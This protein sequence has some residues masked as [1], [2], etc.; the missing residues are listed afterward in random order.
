MTKKNSQAPVDQHDRVKIVKDLDK[1]ILV[2]A[3]AGSGKTESLV[4]RMLALLEENR[5]TVSTLAAV[6]FTNKAAAELRHRFQIRLEKKAQESGFPEKRARLITALQNLE[7]CFIGTIH[8]FCAKLLR[9][10]PVEAGLDPD[11]R[12]MENI[13]EAVFRNRAWFAFLAKSRDSFG[14]E[15]N[16]LAKVG[17]LPEDLGDAFEVL[18][19]FPDI[20]PAAGSEGPPDLNDLRCRLKK[21]LENTAVLVP[22]DVPEKGFDDVQK[23]LRS[24]LFRFR[25][26]GHEDASV[27][28]DTYID[29]AGDQRVTLNRWPTK[30]QAK[31]VQ[32]D[33]DGFREQTVQPAVKAWYEYR[34][35]LVVRFLEPAVDFYTGQRLEH[36][37]LN[38]QDLLLAAA[39]MLRDSPKL[40]RYFQQRFSHILVDEFQDTD[41]I[42]A[43]L[44]F[45]LTGTNVTDTDWQ[46]L[47]PVPGSLFLVGDPKQSIYRFRRADISTYNLV[48]N[49]V[50]ESGGE[51]LSLS[52]N[53]RSLPCLCN[54]CDLV[55][56]RIFPDKTGAYQAQFVSLA[57]FRRKNQ[58][59]FGIHQLKLPKVKY[60]NEK[61]IAAG[62][63]DAIAAWIQY[64]CSSNKPV[65]LEFDKKSEKEIL[66]TAQPGDFMLL[67]RYRKNID[68][69]ARALEQQ[70]L[71]FEI[72]G[73]KG[74]AS[75]DEIRE[76]L[77][78]AKALAAPDN[79]VFTVAALRGMFFGISD[80]ALVKFKKA[81]GRFSC[82]ADNSIL[83]RKD[84]NHIISALITMQ[85][86]RDRLQD[87]PPSL[88]LEKILAD[89]GLIFYL[90]SSD[91]GSSRAGNIFKL[92]EMLRSWEQKETP[93]WK[94]VV[95]FLDEIVSVYDVEESSL[96]PDRK[97]A[98]RLMN[99][100]KAKGLEAPVVIL[101][102]PIGLK[103]IPPDRYITRTGSN[104]SQGYFHF[105]KMSGF[106]KKTISFPW[107]WE[108][109]QAEEK[110]FQTAEEQRLMYVAAT[111]AKNLL[112]IS[113]YVEDRGESSSWHALDSF[114][115]SITGADI[116]ELKWPAREKKDFR[117][118][119][120]VSGD[121]L[122]KASDERNARIDAVSRPGYNIATVT[123]LSKSGA[124]IPP[125]QESGRG[126]GWG[127][128][129]HNVLDALGKQPDA[130][131]EPLLQNALTVEER[132]PLEM[133]ILLNLIRRITLSEFWQ[134]AMESE[135]KYFEVPFC[136]SS[137]SA[138]QDSEQK[139]PPTLLSGVIDLVFKEENGWVIADYKTDEVGDN[140]DEFV[141]YYV[142]QV[143]LYSRFWEKITG[144]KV[145]ET[146]LFF[147]TLNRWIR[148]DP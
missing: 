65:I 44:L 134:R 18:C 58:G 78:L 6:T 32:A 75:A 35:S 129:V 34:H 19:M 79:P 120:E 49:R 23:L 137:D 20:T 8:S 96:F 109:K 61:K 101:A 22:S 143:R 77:L 108:T 40:R 26:L 91:M 41:P 14:D 114:V 146:G 140:L 141:N 10:R 43:E 121:E 45:Y 84:L 5:C 81:G 95:E 70:G 38:F 125:W 80:A 130:K 56:E 131:I 59:L 73:G 9:E 76:L 25:N 89:S 83:A 133:S 117:K 105:K 62:E 127:R 42:Q 112:V 46:K 3:G 7:Q 36:A 119:I 115:R 21:F 113:T 111:R 139:V 63:A 94:G 138:E 142:P 66:R 102:H 54:W 124:D 123:S 47:S 99:L 98:V 135:K 55:F 48:K 128:I 17:I 122:K 87:Y 24:I 85:V 64:N 15:I 126:M 60:N 4:S 33:L 68:I 110:L 100:H 53:F 50:Q 90:I 16:K 116:P 74:F 30:E 51:I 93:S 39:A 28:M 37:R 97:D 82:L 67:F 118:I 52:Q 92:L 13:E 136:M 29:L 144:E 88:V 107:D 103:P 104:G 31:A 132:D 147:T 86:W 106:Q 72:S 69:Y 71:S 148:V 12:E 145:A 11:F 57:P 1:T 2:E 27:L